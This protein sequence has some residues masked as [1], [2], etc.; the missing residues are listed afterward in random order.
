MLGFEQ[1]ASSEAEPS[2]TS[3]SCNVSHSGHALP[4]IAMSRYWKVQ[5]FKFS[6]IRNKINILNSLILFFLQNIETKDKKVSSHID[7][8]NCIIM[9]EKSKESII[10]VLAI[11]TFQN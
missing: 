7:V 2:A 11:I 6:G 4:Y 1:A 3:N 5:T 8:F 10:R 9:L